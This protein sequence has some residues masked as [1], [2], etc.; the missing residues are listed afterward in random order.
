MNSWEYLRMIRP[1]RLIVR[2]E[3]VAM[4]GQ[5]YFSSLLCLTWLI[6]SQ[7]GCASHPS[8]FRMLIIDAQT[9]VPIQG[10]NIQRQDWPTSGSGGE[11][12]LS[13]A[14]SDEHGTF[15]FEKIES[16]YRYNFTIK[17]DGYRDSWVSVGPEWT[18]ILY[19]SP[20]RSD[21]HTAQ[22]AKFDKTFEIKLWKE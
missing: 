15:R 17:N 14:K 1:K 9:G 3:E 2:L 4:H 5:T 16:N 8:E 11:V 21:I 18:R 12:Q 10:A 13:N 22:E 6:V 7:V 19:M 20:L